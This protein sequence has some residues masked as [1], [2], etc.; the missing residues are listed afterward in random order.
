VEI[1]TFNINNIKRRLPVAR[2]GKADVVCL[3]ELKATDAA[4][5]TRALREAG[6]GAVWQGQ[7]SSNG[8]AVLARGAEAVLTR[9]RLPSDPADT[10][11][12]YIEAAVEGVLID[13]LY[14]PNRNPQPD[15][16]FAYKLAWF[17]RLIAHAAELH[18]TGLPVVPAGDCCDPS[19]CEAL[20]KKSSQAPQRWIRC[21][22]KRQL[23]PG[24]QGAR[25]HREIGATCLAAPTGLTGRAATVI[26][27]QAAAIRADRLAVGLRPAQ[28]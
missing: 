2:R 28:A 24:E 19:V 16:K 8:V 14:L 21:R 20:S 17:E 18:A 9:G 13:C 5:P 11:S 23:V 6:Y 1:A 10:Q 3:Q 25:C 22:P 15:P 26:A 27:N 4:F 12:R 7:A